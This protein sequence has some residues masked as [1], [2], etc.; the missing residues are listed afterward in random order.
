MPNKQDDKNDE[1]KESKD[2]GAK[3]ASAGK[4]ASKD[5]STKEASAR[6][7]RKS[8]YK[9][10]E[11]AA[12]AETEEEQGAESASEEDDAADTT[13]SED[14]VNLDE[15]REAKQTS[16]TSA[17]FDSAVGQQ[18]RGAVRNYLLSNVVPEGQTSGEVAVDFDVD[19][20]KNHVPGIL[21]SVAQ[22]FLSAVSPEKVEVKVPPP[23]AAEGG[24]KKDVELA[25]NFDLQSFVKGL[26][27]TKPAGPGEPS[28]SPE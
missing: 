17:F 11:P 12:E 13:G 14:V 22:S 6:K 25:M 3:K 23:E 1:K 21:S 19:F 10:E 28:D 2:S 8:A 24:Q 4:K 16:V 7:V 27:K 26:F 9:L 5:S 20:L 18:V 15:V